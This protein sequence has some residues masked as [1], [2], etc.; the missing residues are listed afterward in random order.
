MANSPVISKQAEPASINKLVIFSNKDNG[1]TSSDIANGISQF[2]YYESIMQDCI[3]ATVIF[4]DTG[5][6]V[7][8][9]TVF[10]GLP[11]VGT[12]RVEL[13]LVDNNDQKLKLTLY[14]NK[15]TP[16]SDSSTKGLFSLDLVSKEFILN[17][18]SRLNKR[19]DGRISDHV[20]SALTSGGRNGLETKKKINIEETSNNYNF[21]GNNK[22]PY[23]TINWLS[24]MAVSAQ[25]QKS[26]ESAGYFFFETSEGFN[27]KSID[28]LL[29]QKQKKSVM[30]NDS[31]DRQKVPAGYDMKALEFERDNRVNVQRKF[32]MGAFSTRIVTFD[33]FSCVY[34][35]DTLTAE[36]KKK[37]L[38]LAG[39]DLPKFNE[40]FDSPDQKKEFSRTTYYLLDT[41]TLPS[42]SSSQ[43]I[44]K[45]AEQNA[46]IKK[47]IN[48]SIMRYNQ[49][50]SS[51][52]TI[53][54]AADLSLHAG[55]AIYVDSPDLSRDTKNDTVDKQTG[56]IYIISDMCHHY[57][58]TGTFTQLKLVR[59]S[60]GRK[61]NHTK[62][63]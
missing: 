53:T 49:L 12:E 1:K 11:L 31:P 39:K 6:A 30:Y 61:G 20:R 33:P 55:D 46:Q 62:R 51:S 36:E 2:Q 37:S 59:D 58:A 8:G 41:G 3:R 28:G 57:T 42:G 13:E 24:K 14:V 54:T 40:E 47:T 34:N 23:Y 7:N 32:E 45:S 21:F 15:A 63:N 56:G 60:S 27:F 9:K 19:F 52:V 29:A 5:N 38:K 18:K 43:Q 4:S 22:K 35:V 16:L 48:Q 17:E 25:N 10:E 50:Y 26:G 44:E